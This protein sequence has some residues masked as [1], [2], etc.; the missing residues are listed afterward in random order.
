MTKTCSIPL[1]ARLFHKNLRISCAAALANILGRSQFKKTRWTIVWCAGSSS[2][3]RRRAPNEH[4]P[5]PPYVSVLLILPINEGGN[6]ITPFSR[7]NGHLKLIEL[8]CQLCWYSYAQ[9]STLPGDYEE[10]NQFLWISRSCSGLW[11]RPVEES[12]HGGRV[13]LCDTS[14][15][16]VPHSTPLLSIET[17]FPRLTYGKTLNPIIISHM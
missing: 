14:P 3:C 16:C 1:M 15:R 5:L 8:I 4:L 9:R 6:L 11:I 17:Q 10:F 13:I 12:D 7:D 2:L